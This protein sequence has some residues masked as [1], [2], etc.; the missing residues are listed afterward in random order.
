MND[1]SGDSVIW[2]FSHP[3]YR[4]L[5]LLS[6]MFTQLEGI[7]WVMGNTYNGSTNSSWQEFYYA[8]SC[9]DLDYLSGC[10]RAIDNSLNSNAATS[11]QTISF[12]LD[13]NIP[14]MLSGL[15][16]GYYT[17]GNPK[18]WA[19]A[20]NYNQS[21]YAHTAFGGGESTYEC[22]YMWKNG[23]SWDGLHGGNLASSNMSGRLVNASVAGCFL[24]N[25]Y[26]GRTLA[27]DF[28]VR[29][30]SDSYAGGFAH[31]HITLA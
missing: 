10:S 27:A 17:R 3:V 11:A 12:G 4:G 2:K 24:Y 13:D 20:T 15:T 1:S 22:G 29:F 21:L 19:S 18:G 9:D 25:G 23:S 26:V 5:E 16:K 30:V 31:G 28:S 14:L 7:H 6:G 8:N